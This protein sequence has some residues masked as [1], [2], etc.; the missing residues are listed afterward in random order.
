MY[1]DI[2]ASRFHLLE[3]QIDSAVS[4][5]FLPNDDILRN[6]RIVGIEVYG[7]NSAGNGKSPLNRAL[8]TDQAIHE[9]FLTFLCDNSEVLDSMPLQKLKADPADKPVL[10]MD[11]VGISPTKSYITFADT[12]SIAAGQSVLVGLYYED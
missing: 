3:V 12:T 7:R 11:L 8:I 4:K 5:I 6:K 10:R 1:Q 2:K 9:S